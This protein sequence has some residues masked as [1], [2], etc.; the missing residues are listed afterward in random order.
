MSDGITSYERVYRLLRQTSTCVDA[1]NAALRDLAECKIEKVTWTLRQGTDK[2]EARATFHFTGDFAWSEGNISSSEV[3]A[4]TFITSALCT[5]VL[6]LHYGPEKDVKTFNCSRSVVRSGGTV[7]RKNSYG[8]RERD[9]Q[10]GFDRWLRYRFEEEASEQMKDATKRLKAEI[11]KM[12]ATPELQ[13]ARQEA[14]VGFCK[15][16]ITKAL[17]PWHTMD[18]ATLQDAWDQFICTAIMRT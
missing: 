15:D 16:D 17:L 18:E 1:W 8:E 2:S 5:K 9:Y 10:D 7:S 14:L 13:K 6:D 3:S 12:K 11:K 4:H